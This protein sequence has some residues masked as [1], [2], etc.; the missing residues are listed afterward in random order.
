MG[1]ALAALLGGMASTGLLLPGAAAQAKRPDEGDDR[2]LPLLAPPAKPPA[3]YL[4]HRS[5]SSHRSHVSGSGHSSG[6][7]PGPTPDRTPAEVV[8]PT[9]PPPPPPKPA[10]VSFVAF[11]GGRIFVDGKLAG[12][13]S[14]AVMVLS[15][16][17]HTIRVENRFLGDQGVTIELREGQTGVVSIEWLR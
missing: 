13:D 11:P 15:P 1:A 5:H 17:P 3:E 4:A 10:T 14:T 9:P 6:Y 16:G 12:S 7:V 2:Y 8:A